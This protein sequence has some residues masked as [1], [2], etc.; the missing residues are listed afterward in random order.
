MG[1]TNRHPSSQNRQPLAHNR[2]EIPRGAAPDSEDG[3]E[4]LFSERLYFAYKRN[5][6]V[7]VPVARFHNIFG[8][9]GSWAGGRE[10]APAAICCKVA[11]ARDG[12][13]IEI[14]GDGKQIRARFHTHRKTAL[15]ET[16]LLQVEEALG[17]APP[18]GIRARSVPWWYRRVLW[19][20]PRFRYIDPLYA[21]ARI[22]APRARLS[23]LLL[24]S[25]EGRR[26]VLGTPFRRNFYKKLLDGI[27]NG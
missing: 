1:R 18:F 3:W 17:V 5:C 27:T 21:F 20:E 8:P 13:E 23:R 10:K 2:T 14:W 7:E 6:G 9:V 16:H 4:K 26:Y 12:G 25:A 11:E 22:V 15:L 19:R 24:R